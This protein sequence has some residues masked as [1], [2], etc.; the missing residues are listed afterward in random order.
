MITL[1]QIRLNG[2]KMMKTALVLAVMLSPPA[3]AFAARPLITDDAGTLGKGVFQVELGFEMSDHRTDDDGVLTREDASSAT[4][5]LSYGILDNLDVL[6]GMPYEKTKIREDGETV[7]N[8]DGIADLTLEAKWRFFEKD[9][10]ALAFKPGVSFPT[11]DDNKGF[12]TGRMTYGA[13]FIAAKDIGP[14]S[15]HLNAGYKRNENKTNERKDMWGGDLAGVV[16][17]A[18]PLKLLANVGMKTNTDR[19]VATDPAFLLGGLVYSIT[20][21]IDLDLGYKRG[22]N[23]A[24]ADNAYIAGLTMK[25]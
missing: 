15:F 17:V 25:F 6:L 7:H 19:T 2:T 3:A 10:F 21:K 14:V 20:D 11:G 13:L 8:E 4:T 23:K 22:L 1:S 12:G 9:G 24:E 16:T 5:T 18:K